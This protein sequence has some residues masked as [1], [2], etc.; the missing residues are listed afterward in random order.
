MK[1]LK[2]EYLVTTNDS[3]FYRCPKGFTQDPRRRPGVPMDEC[4]IKHIGKQIYL[5]GYFDF[6]KKGSS[7]HGEQNRIN[8]YTLLFPSAIKEIRYK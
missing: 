6:N 7:I 8:Q 3:I 2:I 1:K 5:V 4:S